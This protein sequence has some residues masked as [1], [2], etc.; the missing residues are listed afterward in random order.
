MFEI[1]DCKTDKNSNCLSLLTEMKLNNYIKLT[2][3]AFEKSGNIEGQRGVI[4]KSSSA[5]KI[6]DRMFEDF[7]NGAVFPPVVVGVLLPAE[8][9]DEIKKAV[10]EN[11][12]IDTKLLAFL[13]NNEYENISI[14]DG[15]QRS[16]VYKSNLSGNEDRE[17]RVEYWVTSN[18]SSLIYRMLVLNTG[19]VPWNVRRQVEVVYKP[20]INTIENKLFMKYPHL[21]DKIKFYDINSKGK[22]T[23]A[24]EYHKNQ[25]VELFLSYNLRSE[26]VDVQTQLAEDFQKIDMME[27]LRSEKTVEIFT[28]ILAK[29]CELDLALGNVNERLS[30]VQ[31]KF[32]D[33]KSLF[34]SHPARIGFV[35]AATHL[36]VG[37]IGRDK[38][39]IQTEKALNLFYK[40]ADTI[41]ARLNEMKDE[42]ERIIEFLEF[43]V[44]NDLILSLPKSKV[45]DSERNGFKNIFTELLREEDEIQSLQPYWRNM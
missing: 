9:Y 30:Y 6:R 39:P 17:I 33:G 45:G 12:D 35:V 42:E 20:L 22:R 27:T 4:N 26:K 25:I 1:I 32:M 43:D 44:L 15:V 5:S 3:K 14:I 7:V 36:I 23:S 10:H 37:K 29:L 34:S 18:I 31:G 41:I 13:S 16:N 19:Q 2:D 8:D 11:E 24:G 21:N 40:N 38:T 28:E